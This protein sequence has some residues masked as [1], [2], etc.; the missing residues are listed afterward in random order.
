[1]KECTYCG[2]VW[3]DSA[4]VCKACGTPLSAAMSELVAKSNVKDMKMNAQA[5]VIN[6]CDAIEYIKKATV[7][8]AVIGIGENN[9]MVGETGTGFFLRCAGKNFL[10]TNHHVIERALV[11]G[12]VTVQFPEEVHPKKDAFTAEVLASDKIND[13]ALLEVILP[14]PEKVTF[15]ELAD[16]TTLRQGEKVVTVG[17]PRHMKFNAVEGAVSN[18]CYEINPYSMN[19]ILCTLQTTHGNS[20][21]AIVRLRDGAVIGIATA[22][23]GEYLPGHTVCASADAI[24]QLIYAYARGGN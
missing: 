21:G 8:I 5:D 4:T 9:E 24:R 18:T 12:M 2:M 10:V 17:C 22:I 19:A 1:M 11:G 15:L 16:L 7:H 14:V 6:I 13:V 3:K 23:F 20:G